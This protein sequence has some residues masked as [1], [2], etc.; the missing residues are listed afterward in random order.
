MLPSWGISIFNNRTSPGAIDSVGAVAQE[1]MKRLT[2]PIRPAMN[3][4]FIRPMFFNPSY[5][6]FPILIIQMELFKPFFLFKEKHPYSLGN[7]SA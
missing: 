7:H 6:T 4:G 2:P 1:E 5:S 3:N